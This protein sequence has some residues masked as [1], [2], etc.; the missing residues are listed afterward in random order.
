MHYHASALGVLWS[1]LLPLTQLLVLVFLF[2][3]VLPLRIEAYPAFVFCALLPWAWLSSCLGSAGFLFV[4]N[5][6]LVRRPGFAPAILVVVNT[7]SNLLTYVVSLPVLL[8][9]LAMYDRPLTSAVLVLPLL[10]L[11]QATLTVGLGLMVAT[12]NV[13]FRD[14]QHIVTVLL[15]LLFYLTPVFYRAQE[16]SPDSVL[17]LR[18]NPIGA[19]IGDYRAIFFYGTVPAWSSL[20]ATGA[21][22]VLVCGL[23][24]AVYA[25]QQHEMV[26]LI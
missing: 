10:V 2:R 9:V 22:S 19:L 26:D 4:G 24:Y 17:L 5:R 14:V 15:S 11:I 23:G 25:R 18:L 7:L 3:R 12:L 6:D 20:L 13:F 1:L 8:V 16:A 21:F